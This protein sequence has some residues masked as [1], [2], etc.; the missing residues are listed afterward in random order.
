[1]LLK[2][3]PSQ[4]AV[5]G[6]YMEFAIPDSMQILWNFVL[7]QGETYDGETILKLC[8]LTFFCVVNCMMCHVEM[9]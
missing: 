6:A 3:K 9:V 2:Q 1:M 8:V 4:K 7:K 5:S